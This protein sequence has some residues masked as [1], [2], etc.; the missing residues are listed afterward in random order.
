MKKDLNSSK[1][2]SL[3]WKPKILFDNLVKKMVE[4]DIENYKP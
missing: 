4:F 3:G 1:I 2:Y